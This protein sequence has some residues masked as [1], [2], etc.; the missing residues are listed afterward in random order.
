[1][2]QLQKISLNQVARS[3]RGVSKTENSTGLEFWS[4]ETGTP[5]TGV[6]SRAYLRAAV[7]TPMGIHQTLTHKSPL[8]TAPLPCP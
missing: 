2:S 1:M 3:T 6:L 5:S 7:L 4:Y 8:W